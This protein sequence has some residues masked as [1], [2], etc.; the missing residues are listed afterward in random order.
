MA[1]V[2][3]SDRLRQ[4]LLAQAETGMGYQVVTV[5]LVG[6]REFRRVFA[7]NGVLT[8]RAGAWVPPFNEDQ[9]LDLV[10]TH[11]VSGPPVEAR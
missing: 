4:R 11:D 8:D 3:R 1:V 2:I 9:I 5:V 7:V 10:V 6:G